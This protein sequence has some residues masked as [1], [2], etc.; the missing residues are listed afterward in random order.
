MRYT[1][2]IIKPDAVE[3]N[4]I[5]EI[6]RRVEAD[7]FI[8][9]DIKRLTLSKE[10][11]QEFYAVHTGK[12]F[13]DDLVEYMSSGPIVT[14]AL[15]RYNAVTALRNLVGAT[16]P[17]DARPGTVRK[18]LGVD[19]TRNS[20][21]AADSDENAKREIEFFFPEFFFDKPA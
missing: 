20:V 3:R 21:H 11:A 8:V 17:S 7:Q 14:M 10:R 5:G 15:E 1:L 12:D 9:K 19:H 18:D 13:Y 16:K 2:L 6:I 4:L